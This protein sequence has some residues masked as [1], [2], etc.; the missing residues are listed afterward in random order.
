M[1]YYKTSFSKKAVFLEKIAKNRLWEGMTIL[2]KGHRATKMNITFSVGQ[3]FEYYSF[4]NFSEKNNIF[5]NN[6]EK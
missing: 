3:G 6:G 4:N 1:F 5:Q 2:G